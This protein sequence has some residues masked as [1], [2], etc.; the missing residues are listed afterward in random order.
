MTKLVGNWNF[1]SSHEIATSPRFIGAPRN[2]KR[3]G[4]AFITPLTPLI[5]R[6]RSGHA[7]RGAPSGIQQHEAEASHYRDWRAPACQ[8]LAGRSLAI[9]VRWRR[10]RNDTAGYS[11]C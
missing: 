11:C 3:E 6:L 1:G 9:T 7:L 5:L 4:A 10:A 2:D 8:A